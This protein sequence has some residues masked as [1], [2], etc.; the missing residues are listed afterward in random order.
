MEFSPAR[1][2]HNKGTKT[3]RYGKPEKPKFT[4]SIG[5]GV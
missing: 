3:Y 4:H 2:P 1:H 5:V